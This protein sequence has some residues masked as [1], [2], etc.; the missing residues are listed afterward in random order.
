[1]HEQLSSLA[2]GSF[3]AVFEHHLKLLFLHATHR[4]LL[5]RTKHVDMAIGKDSAC[6]ASGFSCLLGDLIQH[7]TPL[8]PI[9]GKV[10]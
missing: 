3:T 10:S 6:S 8:P 4:S 1:M 7:F 5:H 2:L 9:T